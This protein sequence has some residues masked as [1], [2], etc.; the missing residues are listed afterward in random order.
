[1]SYSDDHIAMGLELLTEVP[2][3]AIKEIK[4]EMAKGVNP[5]EYKKMMAFEIVKT[6]A[7]KMKR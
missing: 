6:S 1:M 3:E 7:A 5:M 4:S 2:L